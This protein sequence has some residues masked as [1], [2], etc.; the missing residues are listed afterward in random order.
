MQDVPAVDY[1]DEDEFFTLLSTTVRAYQDLVRGVMREQ[2]SPLRPPRS[3]YEWT[4][5]EEMAIGAANFPELLG[6]GVQTLLPLTKKRG[7]RSLLAQNDLVVLA[8]TTACRTYCSVM[9]ERLTCDC[10]RAQTGSN[11]AILGPVSIQY[12]TAY[13]LRAVEYAFGDTKV[14]RSFVLALHTKNFGYMQ[15][16]SNEL[17]TYIPRHKIPDLLLALAS[18][19]HE[20]LGAQSPGSRLVPDVLRLIANKIDFH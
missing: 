5:M 20:R 3:T 6:Q 18:M 7:L 1:E 13:M 11:P 19:T 16:P 17:R 10:Y 9:N 15:H 8:V 4:P 2:T 12:A 14:P